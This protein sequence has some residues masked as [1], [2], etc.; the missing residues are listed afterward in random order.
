MDV[1]VEHDTSVNSDGADLRPLSSS[2]QSTTKEL[3]DFS[4]DEQKTH[5]PRELRVREHGGRSIVHTSSWN[6]GAITSEDV[7]IKYNPTVVKRLRMENSLRWT[8]ILIVASG[9]LITL[10]GAGSLYFQSYFYYICTGIWC[11]AA[12]ALFQLVVARKRKKVN[13]IAWSIGATSISQLFCLCYLTICSYELAYDL[14]FL[15][16]CTDFQKCHGKP[17]SH[18]LMNVLLPGVGV[19]LDVI[20]FMCLLVQTSVLCHKRSVNLEQAYRQI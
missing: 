16:D 8:I 12:L 9:V 5:I 10:I 6:Y 7:L 2:E 11:G 17:Y 13:G 15:Q 1:N 20:V 14:D 4:A 19:V 3:T 18:N